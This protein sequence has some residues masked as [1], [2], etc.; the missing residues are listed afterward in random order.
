[1]QQY[2]RVSVDLGEGGSDT[3]GPPGCWF[4][5]HQ[6]QRKP[7][8]RSYFPRAIRQGRTHR[9][10]QL[11]GRDDHDLGAGTQ[12][13]EDARQRRHACNGREHRLR[14]R[15]EVRR[16]GQDRRHIHDAEGIAARVY[17]AYTGSKESINQLPSIF[18]RPTFTLLAANAPSGF[19]WLVVV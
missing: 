2:R 10:H 16:Q 15:V 18:V 8:T 11:P 4:G 6:L 1:M 17:L 7:L 14:A 12:P 9:R 3:L 5:S 13:L 19:S